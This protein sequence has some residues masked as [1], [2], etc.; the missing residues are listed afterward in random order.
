MRVSPDLA[1][2][3]AAAFPGVTLRPV[4]AG[5]PEAWPALL[6]LLG[7]LA[8]TLVLAMVVLAWKR[9]ALRRPA[10]GI[11]SA[12]L[13]AAFG[14][15]TYLAL[16]AIPDAFLASRLVITHGGNA[17][18]TLDLLYRLFHPEVA[19]AGLVDLLLV[20]RGADAMPPILA[21]ARLGLWMGGTSLLLLVAAGGWLGAGLVAGVLAAVSTAL[22]PALAVVAG[23]ESPVPAMTACGIAAWVSLEA[24]LD[25]EA[26]PRV[27]RWAL[28]PF[29]GFQYLA[30]EP[31][32]E[33]ALLWLPA[34]AIVAVALAR[35]RAPWEVI[36][37]LDSRV[38]AG[39]T[40]GSAHPRRAW[41][42]AVVAALLV[43]LPALL[44]R[45]PF[46]LW[47]QPRISTY[48]PFL[49][50]TVLWGF[51][52][53]GLAEV[54]RLAMPGLT[55]LVMAGLAFGL[56]RPL[57][58][59]GLGIGAAA[60]LAGHWYQGLSQSD[61]E[62]A[63]LVGAVLPVL[64][65]LGLKALGEAPVLARRM[66]VAAWGM[67]ILVSLVSWGEVMEAPWRDVLSGNPIGAFDDSLEV[68]VA[69]ARLRERPARCLLAPVLA[70]EHL[71]AEA[72]PPALRSMNLRVLR[73]DFDLDLQLG[74]APDAPELVDAL[75]NAAAACGDAEVL[76]GLDCAIPGM[77]GCAALRQ[78][79]EARFEVAAEG[80]QYAGVAAYGR[81]VS[82]RGVGIFGPP[83]TGA[84]GS[85]APAAIPPALVGDWVLEG[86][87]D[88]ASDLPP[89]QAEARAILSEVMADP[90]RQVLVLGCRL[91]AA[92]GPV[93]SICSRA[94]ADPGNPIAEGMTPF[95]VDRTVA[96][97]GA[98]GG[99]AVEVLRALP[100]R[101]QLA[102]RPGDDPG[103]AGCRLGALR[104][105]G[106]G[107]V[108]VGS[109]VLARLVEGSALV[110]VASPVSLDLV[111]D[112][113]EALDRAA[114]VPGGVSGLLADALPD[115]SCAP[116]SCE[117]MRRQVAQ[118][119]K[120][121]VARW[122]EADPEFM[123]A[124]AHD[125][126]CRLVDRDGDGTLDALGTPS[127]P[128]E[129]LLWTGVGPARHPVRA[130]VV[131]V[132]R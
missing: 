58:A 85:L 34:D 108:A 68:R 22:S 102:C 50:P 1:G 44:V 76:L 2:D 70:A 4:Y 132:R 123:V 128:C 105:A 79:L 117:P 16:V 99:N 83:V 33:Y 47:D 67:L 88:L 91:S 98:R 25:R 75:R 122:V 3:L 46:L 40:W 89:E 125:R 97:K 13:L 12:L 59:R 37:D 62:L 55:V 19:R 110:L 74:L 130:A 51:F 6:V 26:A 92:G 48:F 124:T 71:E 54:C 115:A 112:A 36:Q 43:V 80:P 118:V 9:E 61:W 93:A 52:V 131:G 18:R 63:R 121:L 106:G 53:P 28:V 49:V 20:V 31:R 109:P 94:F 66:A 35:R 129:L 39:W 60:L 11:A 38:R 77:D 96:A 116:E 95:G 103:A 17:G 29:L 114:G 10:T 87:V 111:P 86:T 65:M 90:A 7:Y 82:P 107:E 32:L 104:S 56:L 45:V 15:W 41:A 21:I 120:G 64:A 126:A 81:R 14:A 72:V 73:A 84:G 113:I 100:I 24:I 42:I 57:R 23:S 5:A 69:A 27:R 101:L 78:S 119:A 127:A 8:L 30:I